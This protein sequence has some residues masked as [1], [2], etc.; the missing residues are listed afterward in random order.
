M[1]HQYSL[2]GAAP[3]GV[4]GLLVNAVTPGAHLTLNRAPLPDGAPHTAV[5]GGVYVLAPGTHAAAARATHL[6]LLPHAGGGAAARAA[7][8]FVFGPAPVP[9]PAPA[10][11]PL[12]FPPAGPAFSHC[13][14]CAGALGLPCGCAFG[15]ARAAIARCTPR[16]PSDGHCIHCAGLAGYGPCACAH[17]CARGPQTRC[18]PRGPAVPPLVIAPA[19]FVPAPIPPLLL[20]PL[21]LPPPPPPP[22]PAGAACSR[23]RGAAGGG[24]PC[25]FCRR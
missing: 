10:P 22:C 11:A 9:A 6:L 25:F 14:H 8:P 5:R 3:G 13:G 19:P 2:L 15:C 20:P 18:P 21:P 16:K 17:G 7:R 4:V 23:A 12:P 24:A 1:S